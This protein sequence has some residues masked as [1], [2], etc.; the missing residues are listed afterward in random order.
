MAIQFFHSSKIVCS[1]DLDI[2]YFVV[3]RSPITSNF[4]VEMD[5]ISQAR[6]GVLGI[7]YPGHF[8]SGI[9]YFLVK[10]RV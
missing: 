1:A 7:R 10:I 3:G 4:I 6:P 2:Q 5:Q 9:W 8:N